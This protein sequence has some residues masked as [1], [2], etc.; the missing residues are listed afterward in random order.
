ML[1]TRHKRKGRVLAILLLRGAQTWEHVAG[2]RVC[3]TTVVDTSRV[4][5]LR[6][7]ECVG[8]APPGLADFSAFVASTAIDDPTTARA[9]MLEWCDAAEDAEVEERAEALK[10]RGIDVGEVGLA[11][12]VVLLV[13]LALV[14]SHSH[15]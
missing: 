7:D 6:L 4:E 1:T 8:R 5:S 10:R 15:L 9:K 11:L 3:H 14:H 13:S 2:S 12:P